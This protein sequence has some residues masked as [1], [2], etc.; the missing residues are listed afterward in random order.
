M[1]EEEPESDGR[2]KYKILFFLVCFA[3]FSEHRKSEGGLFEGNEGHRDG[4]GTRNGE[5]KWIVG[6]SNA[7]C[8]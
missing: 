7:H 2:K 6:N 4:S 3:L 5:K 1:K 8:I